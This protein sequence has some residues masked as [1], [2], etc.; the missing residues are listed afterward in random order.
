M[1]VCDADFSS[2]SPNY[3]NTVVTADRRK[4]SGRKEK[5]HTKEKGWAGKGTA[6]TLLWIHSF[7][8]L[9]VDVDLKRSVDEYVKDL[10]DQGSSFNRSGYKSVDRSA[11]TCYS[12]I[13]M[14]M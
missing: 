7:T 8:A 3:P 2:P 5:G 12:R 11:D 9:F 4:A 6:L 10:T 13:C 1:C 14:W